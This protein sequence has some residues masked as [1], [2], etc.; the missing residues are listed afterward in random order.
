MIESLY[1]CVFM[2]TVVAI[3]FGVRMPDVGMPDYI[4]WV[5]LSF[6]A[7]TLL[8]DGLFLIMKRSLNKRTDYDYALIGQM[9]DTKTRNMV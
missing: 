9:D 2:Q 4:Q 6:L 5:V 1:K 8:I 7:F 3:F